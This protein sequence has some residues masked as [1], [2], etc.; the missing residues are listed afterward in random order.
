M[1]RSTHHALV[2]IEAYEMTGKE[3]GKLKEK[4]PN[5]LRFEQRVL[6]KYCL[7]D[8]TGEIEETEYYLH[9]ID[10]GDEKYLMFNLETL[11]QILGAEGSVGSALEGIDLRPVIKE[12]PKMD[13]EDFTVGQCPTI[14][15]IIVEMTFTSSFN[16]EST[17]YDSETDVI[18]YLD[19]NMVK[20][21]I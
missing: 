8:H 4:Y 13:F 14:D 15:Y 1:S 9:W 20:K 18:G 3:I 10:D 5:K 12:L 11:D 16:G 2:A 19:N 21:L 17:E 6:P 7:N